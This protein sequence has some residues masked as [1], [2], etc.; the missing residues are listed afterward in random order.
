MQKKSNLPLIIGLSDADSVNFIS[1]YQ[2]NKI[3]IEEQLNRIGAIKFQNVSISSL[4]DFQDIVNAIS[5][6]FLSYVDGNSPRTKLTDNVYTSTE[7]DKNQKITM[8]NEL[9]YSAQWPN[10]L[11]FSCLIPSETGGETLLAD[12]REIVKAMNPE[13][14][15]EVKRKGITYI[16]NLH[17]GLGLG[18]SWQDTF[19]TA[20]P[21]QLETYCKSYNITYQWGE[22]GI[23]RLM[24]PSKGVIRHRT[25]DELI[26]F[27]QIDQFHPVHLGD[28]IYEIMQSIYESTE[29]FPMNVKFGDGTAIEEDMVHE[30][31]NTIETVTIAP[32]WNKNELL[33]IDNE[34]VSHGRNEFSG[35]R[36]VLVSMSK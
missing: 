16:R 20:D 6:K 10:K 27:N 21:R 22:N 9:S 25:T 17:G 35:E 28:E 24:Q 18:P 26:W 32:V 15:E 34:L 23:L 14:V 19:E 33:I 2:T 3:E 29:D 4:H 11:F 13:I 7:Y 31:L 1:Y 5:D 36:K 30:I 8:H 12:S